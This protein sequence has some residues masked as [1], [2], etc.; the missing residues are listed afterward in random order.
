MV[1]MTLLPSSSAVIEILSVDGGSSGS[2]SSGH[3]MKHGESES[4]YSSMPKSSTSY[5]FF[6]L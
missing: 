4:K 2:M 3:S 5:M 6:I 1:S